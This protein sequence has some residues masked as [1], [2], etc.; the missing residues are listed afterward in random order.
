MSLNSPAGNILH[1]PGDAGCKGFTCRV[2]LYRFSDYHTLAWLMEAGEY[3][4]L[5]S[6]EPEGR[7]FMKACESE[8]L[9]MI[10]PASTGNQPT[11][12]QLATVFLLFPVCFK[13][14]KFTYAVMVGEESRIFRDSF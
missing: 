4:M 5:A 1:G 6:T 12:T 2:T 7:D 9:G 13:C 10:R 14:I 8:L 3:Y 11:A